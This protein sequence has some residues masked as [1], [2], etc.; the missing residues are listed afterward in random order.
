MEAMAKETLLLV[1][2][3]LLVVVVVVA[4]TGRGA[5]TLVAPAAIPELKGMDGEGDER[6]REEGND[7]EEEEEEE[8]GSR[9]V[10]R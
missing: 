6:G 10:T 1:G 2:T 5:S 9:R 3:L 7:E 8:E 4:E